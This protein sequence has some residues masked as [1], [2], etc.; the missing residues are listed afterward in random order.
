MDLQGSDSPTWDPYGLA[1]KLAGGFRRDKRG[2]GT[3]RSTN[4]VY[5]IGNNGRAHGSQSHSSWV[6]FSR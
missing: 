2:E 3:G 6:L 5:W 1:E 4:W